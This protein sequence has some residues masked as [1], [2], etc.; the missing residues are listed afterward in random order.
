MSGEIAKING[1]EIADI[2]KVNEV[3]VADI[4]NIN[5]VDMPSDSVSLSSNTLNLSSGSSGSVTVTSSD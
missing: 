4:D 2:S 1:V 3:D 5:W